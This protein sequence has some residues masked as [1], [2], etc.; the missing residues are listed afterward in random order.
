MY[1]RAGGGANSCN[2]YIVGLC[3]VMT[4]QGKTL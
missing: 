1:S 4:S 3:I 2:V